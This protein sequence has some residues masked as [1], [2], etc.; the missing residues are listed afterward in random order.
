MGFMVGTTR[1][2][3]PVRSAVSARL[4]LP[5]LGAKR[6]L[7]GGWSGAGWWARFTVMAAAP[8]NH[9][10][11]DHLVHIGV[12]P[13]EVI[14]LLDYVDDLLLW[15]KDADGHYQ[16]VNTTFLINFNI[17]SRSEI[18]GRTDFDICEPLL[19]HQYRID[20]ERVLAGERIRSRVELVGRFNHT[21]RWSLTSKIPLHDR[22]GKI[23][24]NV[25]I[26]RA[27]K[28]LAQE[29]LFASPLSPAIWHVGQNL[30][31]SIT[32]AKLAKRCGLSLRAFERQ[33]QST[34]G[35]SPREYV[36]NLRVRM[37]CHALVFTARTLAEVATEF[38]FAD[39]SH[40]T[41]EF[42]RLMQETPRSYRL[43]YSDP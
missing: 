39:Q 8:E 42:R 41:K 1:A 25:G 22:A 2:A 43:R 23:V 16:W 6:V 28:H 10:L 38:G 5:L 7:L 11:L 17:G 30:S 15:M 12:E 24:G 20:D 3:T 19:A 35:M 32:N 18:I 13:P 31:D 9:H 4:A 37:S 33:F 27:I 21:A 40:F 36:R 26:T 14:E 29:G 34:Y